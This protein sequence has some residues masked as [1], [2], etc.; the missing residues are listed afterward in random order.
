MTVDPTGLLS[1]PSPETVDAGGLA[2]RLWDHGPSAGPVVLFLHG[3]LDTGRSFDHLLTHLEGDVHALCLDWRGHGASAW[4]PPGAS[5]HPWDHV[6]DLI[7]TLQSLEA[8]GREVAAVVAHSMGGNIAMLA[9][10][11]RPKRVPRLLLI[12]AFGPPSEPQIEQPGRFGRMLESMLTIKK[13]RSFDTWDGA[14]DRMLET[15]YKLGRDGARLM[16]LHGVGPDPS[17]PDRFTFLFDP[18]LRGPTP[19][20]FEEPFWTSLLGRIQTPMTLIR[21]GHGYVPRSEIFD[22]RAAACRDLR[23]VELQDDGHHL[24]VLRPDVIADEVRAL[25]A[26]ASA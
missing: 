1:T 18:R 25:L 11:A 24:H 22:R 15:N 17:D 9:A 7:W 10:G 20:R 4:A 3:Y 19:F 2:L 21:A 12:D 8:S 23:L 14:V 5:Y 13:F 26:R 6:K 16:A